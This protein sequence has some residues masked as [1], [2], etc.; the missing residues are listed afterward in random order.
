MRGGACVAQSLFSSAISSWLSFMPPPI[1]TISGNANTAFC[2]EP[3]GGSQVL[4]ENIEL[5]AQPNSDM[6]PSGETGQL[7]RRRPV[8]SERSTPTAALIP[9]AVNVP[10]W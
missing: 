9:P 6:P 8:P 1:G 4:T 2:D 3:G 5:N 7:K 10:W